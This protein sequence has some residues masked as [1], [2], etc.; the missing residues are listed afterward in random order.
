MMVR[1]RQ[2]EALRV[3]SRVSHSE[4]HTHHQINTLLV[5]HMVKRQ[6][7]LLNTHK[8]SLSILSTLRT[9]RPSWLKIIDFMTTGYLLK[10]A[11]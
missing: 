9:T 7:L 8:M 4:P 1:E 6:K 11:I 5:S 10:H 2:R 3:R